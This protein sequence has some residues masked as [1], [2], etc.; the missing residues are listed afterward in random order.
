MYKLDPDP[1]LK[2]NISTLKNSLKRKEI[3]SMFGF[4]YEMMF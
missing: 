3:K 1:C 2:K 4:F